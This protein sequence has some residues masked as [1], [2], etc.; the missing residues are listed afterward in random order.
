MAMVKQILEGSSVYMNPMPKLRGNE[1]VIFHGSYHEKPASFG[2]D[3]DVLSKHTLLVGGTGCGK[4]TLFYHFVD[5]LQKNM[6]QNDVM[7]IFDSKGDFYSRFFKPGQYVIGNSKQYRDKSLKWNI[8]KEVLADGWDSKDFML[9]SSEICKSLFEERTQRG[10]NPFFPC[11]ARDI[12]SSLIICIIRE[13]MKDKRMLQDMY[14]SELKNLVDGCTPHMLQGIFESYPDMTSICSYISGDNSQSQGVMS[15]LFSVVREVLIGVFAEKGG[16]SIRNFV[17][18]KGRKVLYIEY[19]LSI[20]NVLTPIY[21]LLFDLALKEALGR[22]SNQGN[23]YLICDE[24]KLVPHLQHIDDGVNFGRSLG[25][26]IF[27]GL[28]SIEQLYEIYKE[29]R[30]KNIAAGFSSIYAFKANDVTTRN[31][32]SNLFG[33]NVL[34]EQYAATGVQYKEEKRV[35]QVIEDWDMSRLRVGEAIVCLPFSQPFPFR[36]DQYQ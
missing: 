36:F 20:G 16:F 30:G 31:Y 7:I 35:G 8:F 33:K 18:S 23:V 9:N 19:D 21:R 6:T 5:Q 22:Q 1:K 26:K 34:L 32:I 17:R 27:A 12:L 10:N 11:A 15:E 4:T 3:E 29:S 14:N 2:V 24:F 28:Q 13:A 25:V